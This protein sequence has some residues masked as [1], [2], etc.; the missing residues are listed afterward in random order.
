MG[1]RILFLTAVL[2]GCMAALTAAQ[3]HP[4][5]GPCCWPPP[6]TCACLTPPSHMVGWWTL[7]EA[8]P[9]FY[10]RALGDTGTGFNTIH[11]TGGI[12]G[13]AVRFDGST[14]FISVADQPAINFG[15]GDFSIDLWL[16]TNFNSPSVRSILDKRAS[17]PL[18]YHLFLYK[19]M[20]GLQLA[21]ATGYTN[22]VSNLFIAN[23]LWNHVAVTVDRTAHAGIRFYLNGTPGTLTGD[24]TSHAGSLS[25]TVP[26]IFGSRSAAFPGAFWRGDLDE[27]ELFNRVL[28]PAE[29]ASI[30]TA[31]AAGKCKCAALAI[32]PRAWW[33]FDEPAGSVAF[34]SGGD[35]QGPFDGTVIGAQRNAAGRVR[36][37]LLFNG[38][39]DA[40]SVANEAPLALSFSPG[41]AGAFSIDAWVKPMAPSG[42]IVTDV[43]TDPLDRG[44]NGYSFFYLNGQLAFSVQAID[45]NFN[46][47][48]L[49]VS[50]TSCPAIDNNQWHLAGVALSWGAGGNSAT[51]TLFLD[52]VPVATASA[53]LAGV[54]GGDFRIGAHVRTSR[55]SDATFF[56]GEIDEVELFDRALTQADFASIFAAGGAGKCQPCNLAPRPVTSCGTQGAPACPGGE[57]CDFPTACGTTNT[58]G[59]C[60][61]RPMVCSPVSA[62]VCGCDKATYNNSCEAA[63][64]GISV[65]HTG[66]CP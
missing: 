19:G 54:A 40:V 63:A 52:G 41:T 6:C 18:G 31:G 50:C 39:S 66:P 42:P 55:I 38:T 65:N 14:S 46:L 11:L 7:D 20:L 29:V 33:R 2:F 8:G 23:G 9:A 25:N 34:D 12:N 61:V 4:P 32:T 15:T 5:P 26:L 60:A 44:A 10:D 43:S 1:Y 16:R 47:T 35:P 45:A 57:F 37:D 64:R 21:D 49:D 28:Q 36:G 13:G 62:P 22:Y 51:A 27:I 59:V 3:P 58:G 53:T 56:S 24:P 30:W 48:F 17:G